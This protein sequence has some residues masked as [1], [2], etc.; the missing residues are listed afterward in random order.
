M[1]T[2]FEDYADLAGTSASVGGASQEQKDPKDEFFHSVYLAGKSRTNEGG[3]K[4][5]AGKI[6]IRGI[7]YNHDTINMIITHTKDVK[8]KE[9]KV[10]GNT[11]WECF[12]YKTG[13]PPF[14][15]TTTLPDGSR[16]KC[17]LTS[18]ERALDEFCNP[19]REQMIVAGIYCNPNGSPILTEEKKPIFIFIRGKGMR[20]GNVSEYLSQM[21]NEELP[22][23][24]TPVTEASE[25]FEK[26]VVNNKRFVVNIG[27]DEE[28]SSYG[29]LV[30]V[31]T[32]EKGE[33]ISDETV[34]KIL[35]LSKETV[36][37][38]KEKFD[39]STRKKTTGYEAAGI[40]STEVEPGQDLDEAKKETGADQ[41]GAKSGGE[42]FSF[43][44]IE[45]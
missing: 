34:L 36:E 18:A 41:S 45:F 30:K 37:Q 13:E 25:D 42:T 14:L 31:F 39:W 44:D 32:L 4:E 38:F 15:G 19:C 24:F 43:D 28:E 11:Q 20:Y 27:I 6:Q 17:P 35:K 40:L 3:V 12:S 8:V 10:Q 21:Y 23:L 7:T 22:P 26:R 5:Q 29:N 1:T 2:G 9:K 16:R 33:P